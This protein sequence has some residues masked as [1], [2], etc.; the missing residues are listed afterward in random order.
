MISGLMNQSIIGTRAVGVVAPNIGA[1]DWE[2][3][4]GDMTNFTKIGGDK[5]YFTTIPHF[6]SASQV[7]KSYIPTRTNQSFALGQL[8]ADVY[9]LT[10]SWSVDPVTQARIDQ[11]LANTGAGGSTVGYMQALARQGIA[12][13]LRLMGLY[14]LESGEGIIS[15]SKQIDL[16]ND[17]DG[18][19]TITKMNPDWLAKQIAD[20]ISD[21]ES[22]MLNTASEIV[23]L[24]SNEIYNALYYKRSATKDTVFE[25]SVVSIADYLTRVVEGTGR[26]L[27]IGKDPILSKADTTK[28]K[29]FIVICAPGITEESAKLRP[30][31]NV[32]SF[33]LEVKNIPYN[34]CM[35]VG[36][37]VEKV[38]PETYA[39][40]NGD[41]MCSV[42]SGVVLREGVSLVVKAQYK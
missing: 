7:G 17:P 16:G 2:E 18:N 12:Q 31:L 32:N 36:Q 34:T 6:N 41:I 29:D 5:H 8:E 23:I 35:D 39:G 19:S 37:R 15:G 27:I 25:G 3:L 22:N 30:E 26:K 10:A 14:G 20:F 11:V 40:I 24:T 33:G 28:V 21:I 13:R 1:S 38:Y 42:T 9:T 4:V